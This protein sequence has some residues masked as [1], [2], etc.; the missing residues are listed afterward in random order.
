MKLKLAFFLSLFLSTLS[1]TPAYADVSPTV[2][3]NIKQYTQQHQNEQLALLKTLV[4][5]NSGSPNMPGV[6]QVGKTLQPQLE[7]L[8]FKTWWVKEPSSMQRAGTLMAEHDGSSNQHILLIAHL[9]TVFSKESPFQQYSQKGNQAYGP[10]VLDDK[11][12]D[13]VV[14]Y[15]LKALQSINALQNANITVAFVGDEEDSGKPA[16]ISRKPLIDAAKHSDV[17]LEFE[18]AFDLNSATIARRGITGWM[19]NSKGRSG[20]SSNIFQPNVGDGAVFELARILNSMRV[21]LANQQYLTFNPGLVLGGTQL[22]FNQNDS[23]GSASGKQNVIAGSATASGDLRY[24]SNQQ[25][26]QAEGAIQTIVNHHLPNTSANV[27]FKDGIPAMQPTAGNKALLATYSDVSQQLG[28]GPVHALDAS[29]RGAS[30]ISYVAGIVPKNLAGLGPV[31]SG[32][33]S[34]RE[35]VEINSLPITTARTAVL[36]YQLTHQS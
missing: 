17:A 21:Q 1:I 6:Y 26:L 29:L 9:D 19:I 34:V 22:S 7:Q 5:I 2:I 15:A 16:S 31:G 33:H 30:D 12:G 28:A 27:V 24:I 35:S 3:N 20:H 11:G 13:V 14:L 4:N 32:A 25:K 18:G 10:G 8:G 36:I 23:E